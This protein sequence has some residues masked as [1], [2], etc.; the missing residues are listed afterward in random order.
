MTP[1]RIRPSLFR[2]TLFLVVLFLLAFFLSELLPPKPRCTISSGPCQVCFLSPDGKILITGG[3]PGYYRFG[4]RGVWPQGRSGPFQ[5]WD[6][7]S[8]ALAGR[9]RE[10]KGYQV[11][12]TSAYGRYLAAADLEVTVGENAVK[13]ESR[14]LELIDVQNRTKMQFDLGA[15]IG[16]LAFSPQE[17]FLVVGLAIESGD[18]C[19]MIDTSSG[20]VKKLRGDSVF[21]GFSPDDRYFVL[22]TD[23]RD[24]Q[25]WSTSP[26]RQIYRCRGWTPWDM[27]LSPNAKLAAMRTTDGFFFL[28]LATSKAERFRPVETSIATMLFS[29]DSR[30]LAILLAGKPIEFWDVATRRKHHISDMVPKG[31]ERGDESFSFSPDSKLFALTDNRTSQVRVWDI[32]TLSLLWTRKPEE[33]ELFLGNIA[34]TPDSRCIFV[35]DSKVR[36]VLNAKTGDVD[37]HMWA[38][39]FTPDNRLAVSWGDWQETFMEKIFGRWWPFHSDPEARYTV[40]E[41]ICSGRAL[42]RVPDEWIGALSHD[43]R[44]LVTVVGDN[45]NT[46][47][48]CWDIPPGRRLEWIIG[49]PAGIGV[50]G[51]LLGRR[52]AFT[53]PCPAAQFR[54]T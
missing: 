45:G 3:T 34:F 17:K 31:Y 14:E 18:N 42:I 19:C 11:H 20:E 7:H 5:V 41:D 28:D 24:F 4:A 13:A 52:K 16:Y 32:S 1:R 21:S 54:S 22:V 27:I 39:D 48:K 51:F 37:H 26:W 8:G 9:Y 15:N 44:T 33:A 35:T 53:G 36:E 46:L 29:P 10:G 6:T 12:T 50:L 47:L 38:F 2:W 43:G 25:V 23:Y 30:T 40:V 49:I